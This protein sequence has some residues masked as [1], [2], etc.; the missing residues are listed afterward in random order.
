[1]KK[2]LISLILC[3]SVVISLFSGCNNTAKVGITKFSPKAQL[4]VAANPV[5]VYEDKTVVAPVNDIKKAIDNDISSATITSFS[6]TDWSWITKDVENWKKRPVYGVEK[7]NSGTNA[8]S[9]ELNA[10]KFSQDGT[11]SVANYNTKNVSLEAYSGE[12]LSQFGILLSAGVKTQE[13]LCYTVPKDGTLSIPEGTFTAIKKVG[14]IKTGF[15]AEDGTGRSAVVSIQVNSKVLYYGQL[16]NSV[17]GDSTA[18]TQLSY[19][20]LENINVTAGDTVTINLILNAKVNKDNDVSAPEDTQDDAGKNSNENIYSDSVNDEN[21]SGDE[22][23]VIPDKIPL[24]NGYDATFKLLRSSALS[25][26]ILQQAVLMRVDMEK[27]L[28]TE[29]FMYDDETTEANSEYEIIIG[30]CDRPES[31]KVYNELKD[32]R[33]GHAADY[34]IRM[35]GKKLVIAATTE[36]SLENAINYFMDNYCKDDTAVVPSNL[37]YVYRPDM[38]T[39][40]LGDNNIAS[41]A[42]RTERYPS[43]LT[44]KAATDIQN[45]IIEKTGYTVSR[46]TDQTKSEYEILIYATARSG[47]ENYNFRTLTSEELAD[48]M[49]LGYEDYKITFDGK[50][51]YINAG[52]VSA[53][54][55]A[56]QDLLKEFEKSAKHGKVQI[57]AGYKKTGTYKSKQYSLSDG[58]GLTWND[59]FTGDYDA[60]ARLNRNKWGATN[61]VVR[62]SYYELSKIYDKWGISSLNQ[63]ENKFK[64]NWITGDYSFNL[65]GT[66][67]SGT[68]PDGYVMDGF[69]KTTAV[70]SKEGTLYIEDNALKII[71]R[72]IE[73]TSDPLYDGVSSHSIVELDTNTT[74]NFKY[75]IFEMRTINPVKKSLTGNI[76]L[77]SPQGTGSYNTGDIIPEIDLC[78][79]FGEDNKY[80]H[81]L[82]TWTFGDESGHIS[83]GDSGGMGNRPWAELPEG[84]NFF[85]T[86]HHV[87]VEWTPEYITF[88]LDGEP[89]QTIEINNTTYAAFHNYVQ[90]LM[91]IGIGNDSY[92]GSNIPLYQYSDADE[93]NELRGDMYVDYVRVYQ[94]ND[95]LSDIKTR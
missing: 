47:Y 42:I 76:W 12:G 41:F 94:K 95:G 81:N 45:W 73:N 82:H 46:T 64:G 79:S 53:A 6:E 54:N 21:S 91:G 85:D 28:G 70:E 71:S 26:S 63:L 4:V 49:N 87:G 3:T 92:S 62:G 86:Y 11:V 16:C 89:I 9:K 75:G 18:V 93:I 35:V 1:M 58:Y 72:K 27:T 65:K 66:V 78:E 29:I 74:M 68:V 40:M 90:I 17:A 34:I 30:E 13:A 67:Y 56:V 10:Y 77:N 22:E 37:N 44:V 20:A 31:K 43:V 60:G 15:L 32:Y 39:I 14:N 88:F 55:F 51:V 69:Y 52:S 57:A 23:E 25:G 19:P 48:S 38:Y 80:I 5:F 83:H 59:E 61:E 36:Y 33:A 84:E 24:I 2:R 7:W 8:K 50:R